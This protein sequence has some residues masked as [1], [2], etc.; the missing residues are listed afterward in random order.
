MTAT[1]RWTDDHLVG[2]TLGV[3]LAGVEAALRADPAV[4]TNL[5]M[6]HELGETR[7]LL[8]AISI[9]TLDQLGDGLDGG[10]TPSAGDLA[11]AL[12]DR[13]VQF[14]LAPPSAVH[15]A[16][17]RLDLVARR[18]RWQLQAELRRSRAANSDAGLVDGAIALLAAVVELSARR[19]GLPP[20]LMAE[21][22]CLAASSPQPS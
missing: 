10:R 21:R 7:Q 17:S 6:L 16:A 14:H 13:A 19:R 8:A 20:E 3:V 2:D 15:A 12:L 11:A 18:D 5:G 9:A 1:S 22:L 4:E